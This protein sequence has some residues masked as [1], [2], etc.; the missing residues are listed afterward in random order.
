MSSD[1]KVRS[2]EAWRFIFTMFVFLGHF[3][4]TFLG[5]TIFDRG[6]CS[7][8]LFFMLSGYLLY[9]SYEKK[10]QENV[11]KNVQYALQVF[12][13]KFLY[14]APRCAIC[15]VA[16]V[17]FFCDIYQYNADT[18]KSYIV[19]AL[20]EM[21]L[22]N[23]FWGNTATDSL[24]L[25][26]GATWYISILVYG[27][28][29]LLLLLGLCRGHKQTETTLLIGC[30]VLCTLWAYFLPWAKPEGLQLLLRGFSGMSIGM[31]CFLATRRMERRPSALFQRMSPFL[32][33]AAVL[34]FIYLMFIR[35]S[36]DYVRIML[37][38][39]FFILLLTSF[40]ADTP[41]NR[42][43]DH[44]FS[45]FLGRISLWIYLSHTFWLM[46]FG[47]RA[48]FDL[49]ANP[50]I[51]YGIIVC[52]VLLFSVVLTY[53][54]IV[55]RE[56]KALPAAQ[57]SGRLVW[58]DALCAF[59]VLCVIM[60]H[61][62]GGMFWALDPLSDQ[63]NFITLT[64][65]DTVAH[66]AVPLL[67]M[68]SGM[69]LLRPEK[70]I[71]LRQLFRKY[72]GRV[73][74]AFAG[75]S[76]FYAVYN[77]F[78]DESFFQKSLREWIEILFEGRYH[79]WYCLV[80]IGVYCAIPLLRMLTA[81]KNRALLRYFLGLCLLCN[82]I[83]PCLQEKIPA[84]ARLMTRIDP[85]I[86]SLY[87]GY[88]VAGYYFSTISLSEK[89]RAL[90]RWVVPLSALGCIAQVI[91][92]SNHAGTLVENGWSPSEPLMAIFIIGVFL[93][94]REY[95]DRLF[96][97]AWIAKWATYLSA[98]SFVIYLSHDMF[99]TVFAKLGITALTLN[100]IVMV[101]LLLF[102]VL[103][104]SLCVVY[105][106]KQ[107]STHTKKDA[108]LA[109]RRMEK[110]RNSFSAVVATK[111]FRCFLYGALAVLLMYFAALGQGVWPSQKRLFANLFFMALW[112]LLIMFVWACI[113]KGVW[114]IKFST[115][116]WI[117]ALIGSGIFFVA[118]GVWLYL[119]LRQESTIKTWDSAV[120]WMKFIEN[121][122]LFYDDIF[123]ALARLVHTFSGEYSDLAVLPMLPI[124]AYSGRW[125]YRYTF[126][127]YALYYVPF[128]VLL[129][130]YLLR[131]MKRSVEIKPWHFILCSFVCAFSVPLFHPVLLGYVDVVGLVLVMLHLHLTFDNDLQH[132][133]IKTCAQLAVLSLCLLL[134]RRWYAFWIVGFYFSFGVSF[135]VRC[136]KDKKLHWKKAGALFANL[137]VIAGSCLIWLAVVTPATITMFLANQ[138]SEAYAAYKTRT[139][140]GDL[141]YIC[142]DFGWLLA[143]AAMIGVIAVLFQKGLREIGVK[144]L[145]IF[146]VSFALFQR[147]Q[148]A[149]VHHRYLFIPLFLFGI[150]S[151]IILSEKLF[152][153]PGRQAIFAGALAC[154]YLGNFAVAYAIPPRGIDSPSNTLL[155]QVREKPQVRGDVQTIQQLVQDINSTTSAYNT[156]AYVVGSSDVS[157]QEVL[158]RALLPD[159]LDATPNILSGSMIDLRDGFPSSAFLAD[160]VLVGDP[161][162]GSRD[163]GSEV[164]ARLYDLFEENP[165][166]ARYYTLSQVYPLDGCELKVYQRIKPMSKAYVDLLQD[167][168][169]EAY[170]E[171]PFVYQPNYFLALFQIRSSL[172]WQYYSW[173]PLLEVWPSEET[174]CQW[175]LDGEFDALQLTVSNWNEDASLVIRKDDE[176]PINQPLEACGEQTLTV[177]LRGIQRLT[178]DVRGVGEVPIQMSGR[179][180]ETQ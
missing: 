75:W 21:L 88:F 138:Y 135:L 180:D 159:S 176:A 82:I 128:G 127:V 53:V 83:M 11:L 175:Q 44:D 91:V 152:R 106:A 73:A 68:L 119:F 49:Q 149:G 1:H 163:A 144:Q 60:M 37:L 151:A 164:I 45:V 66:I 55:L 2:I 22:L 178:I 131:V 120:Y 16:T 104:C 97:K 92:D 36:A 111:N 67:L 32:Q 170:P 158:K 61:I 62:S 65:Y 136:I 14:F 77:A 167:D 174:T 134:L 153:R 51:S 81:S 95:G 80:L 157:S 78:F 39:C 6:G 25:I 94:F 57:S 162:Q 145:V 132:F 29:L 177:E 15:I 100:P 35:K 126:F 122:D 146:T 26:N 17:W 5:P 79:L 48:G 137:S 154:I 155:T 171:E 121:A 13:K 87:V 143:A 24:V 86:F 28:F 110:L 63:A 140:F 112:A 52:T 113:Q 10:R 115:K 133:E 107:F 156:K 139:D 114:E 168:L 102:A 142:K 179:L 166:T 41:L 42:L 147:V 4:A 56:I 98:G 3:Q 33:A 84:A 99:I 116:Q 54:P 160:T 124:G 27:G 103:L 30:A 20:R 34:G 169:K 76:A 105:L 93:L 123:G 109:Q 50:A 72:I 117:T 90:L 150:C 71:S 64:V 40:G 130:L 58:A 108:G 38:P 173:G 125:F 12:R 47:W 18:V 8:E 129:A 59:A 43:L 74:A 70:E 96:Q 69:F 172:P 161:L 7:V 19:P 85:S 46:K 9:R 148:S 165:E 141:I 118:A 89:H 101:P 31:L 23:G